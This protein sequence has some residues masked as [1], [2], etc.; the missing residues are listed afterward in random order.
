MKRPGKSAVAAAHLLLVALAGP[1]LAGVPVEE[2]SVQ[3]TPEPEPRAPQP[4]ALPAES[5]DAEGLVTFYHRLQ[6]LED[7]VRRLTGLVEELGWRMD[8][9]AREQ[10]ERYIEIDSRLVDLRAPPG[11]EPDAGTS[12][13]SAPPP[14]LVEP[15]TEDAAYRA[16]F[17]LVTSAQGR[18]ADE[19]A[20]GFDIAIQ[21]FTALIADYPNGRYT[22][23][24][25]YWLG[26]LQLAQGDLE[27]SRQAFV[28]V[29]NLFPDHAKVRDA[30]YKLGVVYHR[31]DDSPRALE[32]LERVTADFPGSSAASL[33]QAYAAE[34]RAE[35]P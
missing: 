33:A 1:A 18:S 9:L 23:N 31:L 20:A 13:E 12:G 4:R 14:A 27:L 29:V 28:Q 5:G 15:G 11:A 24:A 3:R 2:R 35:A 25:F 6:T 8:R 22:A 21:R 30:L 16:A 34:I 10:R 17:E 19:Q 7:D 32:H 26:E